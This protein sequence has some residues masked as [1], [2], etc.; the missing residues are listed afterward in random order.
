MFVSLSVFSVGHC[1]W[2]VYVSLS[3]FFKPRFSLVFKFFRYIF[4]KI[5]IIL[6]IIEIVK[7]N[8]LRE[9]KGYIK[10]ERKDER[11]RGRM[12]VRIKG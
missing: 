9:G 10:R 4:L 1:L 6:T 3:Q 11:T 7:F 12:R 5:L 2:T 8:I